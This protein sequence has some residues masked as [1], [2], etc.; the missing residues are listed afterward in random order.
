MPFDVTIWYRNSLYFN[1]LSSFK[2]DI[3]LTIVS[4]SKESILTAIERIKKIKKIFPIVGEVNAYHEKGL[5]KILSFSNYYE[6]TRDPLLKRLVSLDLKESEEQKI[7][8]ISRMVMANRHNLKN[9]F[10]DSNKWEFYFSHIS[11]QRPSCMADIFNYLNI[12]SLEDFSERII[13]NPIAFLSSSLHENKLEELLADVK[14][15]SSSKREILIENL[16][17][18]ISGVMSQIYN[19]KDTTQVIKHFEN[20][21]KVLIAV[22]S[23]LS[24]DIDGIVFDITANKQIY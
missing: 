17:W 18:E 23:P 6:L 14:Q 7:V 16:R 20:I 19:L 1:N 4:N 11:H 2:S 5:S 9:G 12:D 24:K 13:F 10:F 3:D 8:F 15:L 21:Q 22:G